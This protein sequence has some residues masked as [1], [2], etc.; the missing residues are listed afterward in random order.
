MT[1]L[2][3]LNSARSRFEIIR[4]YA[5]GRPATAD[6]PGRAPLTIAEIDALVRQL[7]DYGTRSALHASLAVVSLDNVVDLAARRLRNNATP[8]GGWSPGSVA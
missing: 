4:D 3:G 5:N 7:P 8:I 6:D 1:P 2:Y